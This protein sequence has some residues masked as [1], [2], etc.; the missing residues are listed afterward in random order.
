MMQRTHSRLA[1]L[2]VLLVP[3]RVRAAVLHG[4]E[5][6]D[7]VSR[8]EQGPLFRVEHAPRSLYHI[9]HAEPGI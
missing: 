3:C 8:K 2:S 4:S 5:K 6:V 1:A 9:V 7:V